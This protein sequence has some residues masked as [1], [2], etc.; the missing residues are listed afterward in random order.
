[1]KGRSKGHSLVM[2]HRVEGKRKQVRYRE[3]KS[4]NERVEGFTGFL[5]G[6]IRVFHRMT[7]EKEKRKREKDSLWKC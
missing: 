5:L 7:F 2:V 3:L 4:R 6:I 1:M